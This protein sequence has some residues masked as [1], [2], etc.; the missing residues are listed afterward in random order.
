[1]IV[2][3]DDDILNCNVLGLQLKALNEESIEF[4]N[5]NDC[6][7]Y[8]K[9]NNVEI[10]FVDYELEEITIKNIINKFNDKIPKVLYTGYNDYYILHEAHEI[11]IK[12][13]LCKPI[14]IDKVKNVI[15]KIRKCC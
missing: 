9:N 14:N 12:Y 3:L 13:L 15:K 8:C 4:T 1:M 7:K 2:V 10:L 6:I 5:Y 11:G